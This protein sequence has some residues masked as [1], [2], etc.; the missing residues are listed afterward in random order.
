MKVINSQG[1]IVGN[2]S[3]SVPD[4]YFL[5]GA[6]SLRSFSSYDGWT[7]AS[8]CGNVGIVTSGTYAVIITADVNGKVLI[9]R[10]TVEVTP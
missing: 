10:G 7:A 8:C 6:K 5:P 9:A 1:V 2:F 3:H 4:L